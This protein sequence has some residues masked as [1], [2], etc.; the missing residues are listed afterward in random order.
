MSNNGCRALPVGWIFLSSLICFSLAAGRPATC[1]AQ[2]RG[3]ELWA[4]TLVIYSD[5]DGKFG[6]ADLDTGKFVVMPIYQDVLPFAEGMAGVKRDGR[7]GFI[8]T[9]GREVIPPQFE[10]VKPFFSNRA[11]VKLTGEWFFINRR[12]AQVRVPDDLLEKGTDGIFIMD[13]ELVD[14]HPGFRR[15]MDLDAFRMR[16]EETPRDDAADRLARGLLFYNA[17]IREYDRRHYAA[18]LQNLEKALLHLPEHSTGHRL[19][20]LAIRRVRS[21]LD[22]GIAIPPPG[23]PPVPTTRRDDTPDEQEWEDDFIPPD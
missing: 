13:R 23:P 16:T 3:S 6:F 18:S 10:D 7:W 1:A 15:V 14:I 8:D 12:G 2:E 4:E 9:S 22:S 20:T 21:I 5:G 19:A 11:A 17:G